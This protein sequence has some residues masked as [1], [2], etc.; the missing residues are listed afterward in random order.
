[1]NTT[2]ERHFDQHGNLVAVDRDARLAAIRA[3]T[4]GARGRLPA[5]ESG[6]SISLVWDHEPGQTTGSDLDLIVEVKAAEDSEANKKDV[7]FRDLWGETFHIWYPNPRGK[8]PRDE[9]REGELKME[10]DQRRADR[11]E[12]AG[13]SSDSDSDVVDMINLDEYD[14]TV[15]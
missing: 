9:E 12:E 13:D 7:K 3:Q 11:T 14:S 15:Q 4:G 5:D 6:L 10:A 2:S 8:L 1:M